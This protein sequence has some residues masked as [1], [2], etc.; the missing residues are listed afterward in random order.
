MRHCCDC[1][2]KT[3][4]IKSDFD[5]E[6]CPY[7]VDE[8]TLLAALIGKNE[9]WTQVGEYKDVKIYECTGCGA[10]VYCGSVDELTKKRF[11][12]NC[13]AHMSIRYIDKVYR[14]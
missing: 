6:N 5:A 10:R 7:F 8:Q 14:G 4:C 3:K 1:Y 9:R 12:H 2:N 11:C 13:G